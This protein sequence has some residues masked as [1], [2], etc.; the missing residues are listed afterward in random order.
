MNDGDTKCDEDAGRGKENGSFEAFLSAH[1]FLGGRICW[2]CR[3][4]RNFLID[5]GQADEQAFRRSDEAARRAF[6]RLNRRKLRPT[7]VEGILT[8]KLIW[9]ASSQ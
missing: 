3:A 8:S 1:C 4:V 2:Q 6:W 7:P 9:P 5:V